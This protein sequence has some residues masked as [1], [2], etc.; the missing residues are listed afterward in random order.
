MDFALT[1]EQEQFAEAIRR[2]LMTEMTPELTRELWSTETGRSDAL[3]RQLAGQ[4]LTAL[5]VPQQ[6][7]GLGLGE[8][9]WAPLAQACGYFALPEP[10]LDT[11]LVAA[12]LLRDALAAA[13]DAAARERCVTLL[14]RIAAGDAR[15]AVAHPQERLVADAHV[16]DAILCAHEGAVHLLRPDQA[17]LTARTGLDPSRRLF[18]LAWTPAPGTELIPSGSGLWE[19][20]LN[21]GALGV[22]AQQLGLTQ[23]MLDLAIDYSAQRKQFGKAIGAYQAAKH[24]LADVA[25]QLEFAKPVLLRA[26]AA[27][28]HGLPDRNLQVGLHVSHARVA[29]ARCAWTAARQAIQVHGAMGYTWELDLQ[30]FTKRAWAL[31]GSWGDRAFHKA[32]L[33]AHILDGEHDIGAGATFA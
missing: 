19:M 1:E 24:L 31:A 11:A 6:Q 12:G 18:E 28:A 30:I 15:V 14:E 21:R 5:L 9:E 26:A 23:R 17:T 10:L 13:P 3:W 25:I 22:A 20:A 33:G 7:G 8:V 2:F 32:R 27:L 29:A 16:A 4:G